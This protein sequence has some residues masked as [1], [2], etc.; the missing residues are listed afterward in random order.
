MVGEDYSRWSVTKVGMRLAGWIW[1]NG[2]GGEDP[3]LSYLLLWLEWQV[4]SQGITAGVEGWDHGISL[5]RRKFGVEE[6]CDP[7]K[8]G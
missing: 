4:D 3:Q 6:L 7:L 2:G 1:R 8:V 5:G